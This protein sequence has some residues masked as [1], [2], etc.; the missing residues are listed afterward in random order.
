M[1]AHNNIHWINYPCHKTRGQPHKQIQTT[2]TQSTSKMRTSSAL[3][4]RPRQPSRIFHMITKPFS[5][6]SQAWIKEHKYIA[7]FEPAL[8]YPFPGKDYVKKTSG[9]TKVSFSNNVTY[10]FKGHRLFK[11]A[12]AH[13]APTFQ[14]FAMFLVAFYSLRALVQ[15][16]GPRPTTLRAILS[17]NSY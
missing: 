1:Q 12:E 8:N 13:G 15:L 4:A 14:L 7:H 2:K 16:G 10:R 11:R 3:V 5:S 17:R 6:Y 9:Y